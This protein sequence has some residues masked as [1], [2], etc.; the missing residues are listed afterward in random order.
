MPAQKLVTVNTRQIKAPRNMV[1]LSLHLTET[2]KL[3]SL[4]ELTIELPKSGKLE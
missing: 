4:P 3:Y 1:L 2:S